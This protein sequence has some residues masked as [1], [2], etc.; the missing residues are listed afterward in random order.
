MAHVLKQCY[1]SS[2][3]VI[4][5]LVTV[6][7]CLRVKRLSSLNSYVITSPRR[8]NLKVYI[9]SQSVWLSCIANANCIQCIITLSMD[10]V[11]RSQSSLLT[12]AILP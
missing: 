1:R 2:L 6:Y 4:Q 9:D 5:T 7:T 11:A 10:L 12:Q 3:R 8:G